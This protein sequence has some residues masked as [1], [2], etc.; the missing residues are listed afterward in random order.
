MKFVQAV[1]CFSLGLGALTQSAYA[2]VLLGG[3]STIEVCIGYEPES[4]LLQRDA[5]ASLLNALSLA[6]KAAERKVTSRG[7]SISV[8]TAL[9][10][11]GPLEVL[12]E[13]EKYRPTSNLTRTALDRL[14]NLQSFLSP[15]LAE[16]APDHLRFEISPWSHLQQ[17]DAWLVAIF[18]GNNEMR[19]ICRP[20]TAD[21][22]LTCNPDGCATQ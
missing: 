10:P 19:A 7:L 8:G 2:T 12:K 4:T 22:N 6:K 15:S 20:Y 18:K 17:C 13:A 3:R 21:C 9:V 1:L 11:I 16:L 14:K 5:E